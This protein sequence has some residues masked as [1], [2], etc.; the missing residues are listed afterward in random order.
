MEAQ[1]VYVIDVIVVDSILFTP[2]REQ[3]RT[4]LPPLLKCGLCVFLV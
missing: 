4:D 2:Q 1:F 3:C